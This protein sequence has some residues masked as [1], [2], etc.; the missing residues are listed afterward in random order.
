MYG[1]IH[2]QYNRSGAGSLAYTQI[3][4]G[5]YFIFQTRRACS[6]ARLPPTFG[7][8]ASAGAGRTLDR[9]DG[10]HRARGDVRRDALALAALPRLLPNRKLLPRHRR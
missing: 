10:G 8:G 3:L 1:L 9:G 4:K 2:T 5:S 7:A 6:E